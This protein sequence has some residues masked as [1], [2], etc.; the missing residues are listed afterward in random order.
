MKTQATPVVSS[1]NFSPMHDDSH[2]EMSGL[3]DALYD[4]RLLIGIITLMMTLFG[5]G[6]A[7]FAT[8]IYQADILIQ[9]QDNPNSATNMLA[10]AE[11]MFDH[12]SAASDEMDII[13]SRLVVGGTVQKLDL[14][15]RATPRYFPVLGRWL[16][17]RADGLSQP[18]L[19]GYG[20]YVWGTEKVTVSQFDLPESL[21]GKPFRIVAEGRGSYRLLGKSSNI[22]ATGYV[23][24]PLTI[25][26]P[27]GP[28]TLRIEALSGN[29]GATFSLVR[30][31]LVRA[32]EDLQKALR[33]TEK[34]KDADVITASLQGP[35]RLMITKVLTE[36]GHEYV[37]QNAGRKSEEAEKS[38][39]FLDE[40]LPK[41]KR[42]LED[43]E[44]TFNQFRAGNATLDLSEEGAAVLQQSVD[45]QG[46]IA[47][48]E[49]KHSE[50]MARF[51]EHHPAMISVNDQLV[52][53]KG[54]LASIE[55]RARQLPALEQNE[56]RLQR[57]VQVNTDL[58]TGLLNTAQQLRL[59]HA[60]KTGNAR[61]VDTAIMP[62][63]PV[64]PN[65]KIV[66]V[67]MLLI[68][69]FLGV[70]VGW[71]RKRWFGAVVQPDE[72]EAGCGLPVYAVV[73]F[74]KHQ[75]PQ[76]A[77]KDP[78]RAGEVSVLAVTDSDSIS[79]ESLR[80]F[81]SALQFILLDAR[82]NIVLISGPTPQIGKSFIASNLATVLAASNQRVLLIDADLRR[83]DLSRRFGIAQTSG[84]AEIILGCEIESALHRH[85]LPNLDIIARGHA[86]V[87][88]SDLLVHPNLA[89]FLKNIGPRYDVVII[90]SPPVLAVTDGTALGRHAGT[91]FLVVRQGVTSVPQVRESIK[92]FVQ[93][94]IAVN[95]VV[96]NG[97]KGRPGNDGYGY[98]RYAYT[99]TEALPS[100]NVKPMR[101]GGRR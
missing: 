88:P 76:N 9:V 12:K 25:N 94:G 32:I 41:I 39:S 53:L 15:I 80:S 96:F 42:Q 86:Q 69:I 59:A 67:L 60:G 82:N 62:E 33:I 81:R 2:L 56:L 58:Y 10:S 79:V 50:L 63:N 6:Y 1:A 57:D 89:K 87:N 21:L 13:G 20:G 51:T 43:S 4:S 77:R 19:F 31:S 99:V 65:R 52:A 30:V 5:I 37:H 44:V 100:G 3:I 40:Q 84:L 66:V 49:Q 55:A 35:D 48:L 61:L 34:N 97:Y 36:I 8:P 17:S 29:A 11:Q 27:D 98:G 78:R 70:G 85:V 7:V 72:I 47:D 16:A 91:A 90:D 18:G 22:A 64:K 75:I 23:G 46:K 93:T 83:G 54:R 73:P 92:R 95:G 101:S 28:L 45:V 26:T 38:L 74:S 14:E 71:V 24:T 68:G